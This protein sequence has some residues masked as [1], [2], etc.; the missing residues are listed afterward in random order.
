MGRSIGRSH[1]VLRVVS[2]NPVIRIE[3]AEQLLVHVWVRSDSHNAARLHHF[4]PEVFFQ[5]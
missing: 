4:S 5:A 3:F 1:R 2:L